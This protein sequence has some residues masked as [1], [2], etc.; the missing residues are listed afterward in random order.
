MIQ[1]GPDKLPLVPD[2]LEFIQPE[3]Q[4]IE[5]DL[6]MSLKKALLSEAAR[7]VGV[8]YF[9]LAS[10]LEGA[11]FSSLR[12]GAIED[13]DL[14][15]W[16][17]SI[18]LSFVARSVHE[19]TRYMVLQP[20][21]NSQLLLDDVPQLFLPEFEFIDPAKEASATNTIHQMK[22]ISL[23]EVIR[24]DNRDPDETF[25]LL[26]EDAKKIQDYET[27]YGVVTVDADDGSGGNQGGNTQ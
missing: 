7:A 2:G 5:P 8:S 6:F 13:K 22:G 18:L 20:G 11:N 4:R 27:E 14:F 1:V 15:Y 24:K 21:V 12:M 10:D 26:A 16:L 25:R 23:S 19:W 3:V 9:S 17:L